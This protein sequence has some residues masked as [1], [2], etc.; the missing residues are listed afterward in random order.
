MEHIYCTFIVIINYSNR[1]NYLPLVYS[2]N[3]YAR[4]RLSLTNKL[5]LKRG[6]NYER[7][8]SRAQS[9]IGI[10]R[11]EFSVS[12]LFVRSVLLPIC[13]W[14]I[15]FSAMDAF[16]E[17][18]HSRM[19]YFQYLN[20]VCDWFGRVNC[21]TLDKI[22][23]MKLEF[24]CARVFS[25]HS[26]Q[27]RVRTIWFYQRHINSLQLTKLSYDIYNRKN[28]EI[29]QYGAKLFVIEIKIGAM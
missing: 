6:K 2:S 15:K 25:V 19:I 29:K 24:Q 23:T 9:I 5:P 27:I 12:F 10:Y 18:W 3:K 22:T 4:V 21:F 11:F 20:Y 28:V 8:K 7:K 16:F 14:M 17:K 26:I 13:W 1:N